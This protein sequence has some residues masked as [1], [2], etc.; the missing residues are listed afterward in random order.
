MQLQFRSLSSAA[1]SAAIYREYLLGILST[2]KDAAYRREGIMMGYEESKKMDETDL[3]NV[4]NTE[5][6]RMLR[7]PVAAPTGLYYGRYGIDIFAIHNTS[8]QMFA[9]AFD[10][11]ENAVLW[12]L[13]DELH[14]DE[15]QIPKCDTVNWLMEHETAY[16]DALAHFGGA[17][18]ND[19]PLYK[20]H[21]WIKD[22][23][24]LYEDYRRHFDL[25]RVIDLGELNSFG[26]AAE[27]DAEE[28]FDL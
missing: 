25:D 17:D 15:A 21:G 11:E 24:V 18:L 10:H 19:V 12:L 23:K 20:I 1:H 7:D 26:E 16:N 27:N 22:H 4:N 2:G 28:E 14:E 5:L 13:D 9:A 6:S 8:D 3:K